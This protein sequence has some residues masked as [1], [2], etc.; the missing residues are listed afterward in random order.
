[1][2]EG[3]IMI[4]FI[5]PTNLNGAGLCDEIEAANIVIN[6]NTSPLIDGQGDFWLDV[7]EQDRDATALIVAAHNGT[8]VAPE[9]TIQDKLKSVGLSIDDLKAAL[10]L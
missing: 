9:P 5:K 4:K 1:M 2:S 8:M 10:G 7:F 3:G 6:R